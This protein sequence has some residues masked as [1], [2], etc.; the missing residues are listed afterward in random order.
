MADETNTNAVDSAY[1][2]AQDANKSMYQAS[3]YTVIGKLAGSDAYAKNQQELLNAKYQNE[4][5]SA[6]AAKNRDWQEYMSNTANQRAAADYAALGFS[7]LALLGSGNSASTPSGATASGQ[8]PGAHDSG[9]AQVM[10]SLISALAT[11]AVGSAA[12]NAKMAAASTGANAQIAKANI[13][14]GSLAGN[15]AMAVANSAKQVAKDLGPSWNELLAE[16][17]KIPKK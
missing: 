3:D 16:L 7:P 10:G 17:D 14:R 2:A 1:Q 12:A 4:F 5:N 8:K 9:G 13:Y 11:I 6:E 15:S